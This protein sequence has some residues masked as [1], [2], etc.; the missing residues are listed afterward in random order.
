MSYYKY[1]DGVR[2]T[3]DL[4][5][6]AHR[7]TQGRG[8][9][10]ISA[11]EIAEIYQLARD[12]GRITETERRTLLY[13][14]QTYPLTDKARAWFDEKMGIGGISASDA[15]LKQVLRDEYDLRH[16]RWQIDPEEVQK[17]EKMNPTRLFA[18]AIRGAIRAF[19]YY[20][21]GQLSLAACVSRRDLAYSV[22]TNPEKILRSVLDQGTLLLVPAEAAARAALSWDLP[23]DLDLSR[24]WVWGLHVPAYDPILFIAFVLRD[25]DLQHSKGY[26]SRT[27]SIEALIPA[28]IGQ[29]ANLH[30]LDWNIDSAEVQAQL[31]LKP[32]QNFGNALFSAVH[33]AIFNGESSFSFRDF[34]RQ[35]IWQDPEIPLNDYMREYINSGTLHLIP[36]DYAT[37]REAGTAVFPLPQSWELGIDDEW[38]FGLEMPLKTQVRFLINVPRDHHDG[39]S[40]WNDGFILDEHPFQEGLQQVL[41]AEFEIP[42]LQLIF[43]EAEYR[44]QAAAYGPDWRHAQGLLRMALNTALQ[45]YLN[46]GSLFRQVAQ[47]HLNE[48]DPQDFDDLIEY[49]QA[50][51][52]HI[53]QYLQ[54]ASLEFLP[55]ELP[56]NNPI[57]GESVEDNWLFF[58]LVPAFSSLGFF[59]VIPRWPDDEESAYIYGV[60]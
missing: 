23:D 34:I 50:I 40:G 19:L 58:L 20:N 11:D 14:A 56:D 35:E 1:I 17:Q 4:L 36:R 41:A 7:H 32:G 26:F 46:P 45:D 42:G 2:Y 31:G 30:D 13:I 22:S 55:I 21:Q 52:F 59:I 8:E 27:A 43:S 44:A 6:A 25:Q 51:A 33:S 3:R 10:R 5:D 38:Y 18:S 60:H 15:V 53:H 39:D 47:A 54:T 28:V 24:Y 48:I 49:R 16:I 57:D 29:Y 37:Q 12:G 9:Y